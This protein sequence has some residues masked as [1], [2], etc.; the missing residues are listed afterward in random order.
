MPLLARGQ[1][2]TVTAPQGIPWYFGYHYAMGKQVREKEIRRGY[3]L[4]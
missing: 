4:T 3:K 1:S 2:A